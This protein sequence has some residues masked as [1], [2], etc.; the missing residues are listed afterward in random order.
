MTQRDEGD[1][2]LFDRRQG[3]REKYSRRIDLQP[4]QRAL[5]VTPACEPGHLIMVDT[6]IDRGA[7]FLT[8]GEAINLSEALRLAAL[9]THRGH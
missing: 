4:A 6:Y 9:V 7:L 2:G 5:V 8:V 1:T 3:L